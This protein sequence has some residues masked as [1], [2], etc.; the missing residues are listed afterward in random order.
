MNEELQ[1]AI[2][3]EGLQRAIEIL[4]AE[5]KQ[6]CFKVYKD[7]RYAGMLRAIELIEKELETK[8]EE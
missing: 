1:R 4:Q 3:S 5:L 2:M 7:V 6:Y 8:S